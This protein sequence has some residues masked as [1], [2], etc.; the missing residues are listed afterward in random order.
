MFNTLG[1]RQKCRHFTDGIGKHILHENAWISIQISLKCI[2]RGLIN[3]MA[4]L[5]Q[6]MAWRK[7]G[8]KLLSEPMV[9]LFTDAYMCL[10]APMED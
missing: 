7:T 9:T 5:V 6:T 4:A 3:D 8:D 10:S 2:H 1:S